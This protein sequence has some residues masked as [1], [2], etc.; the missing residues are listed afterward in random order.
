MKHDN[1][2]RSLEG[3][4][5]IVTGAGSRSD[6]I[7]NGRASAI[8]LARHGAR[9]ALI[10]ST[11]AWAEKTLDMIRQEAGD[12]YV[13]ECDV[14]VDSDCSQAV[15]ETIARWGK[16]DILVNNVG[17]GGP[18]GSAV[19][20]DLEEWDKAL[21]VN[22]TS[23]MLMARHC[24]PDMRSRK[25]GS[26]I[27]VASVAGLIGGH[28]SLLYPT[29]K[30]A[31]VNMTRAMAAHHGAEGIRVN[32]VA[33]GMVYTPMVYANGMSQERRIHRRNR[34]LLQTEGTAWDVGNAIR[35]LASDEAGWVTGAILPVDAG[36]TA[37]RHSY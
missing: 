31:V 15:K 24:I 26:I 5:A 19:D 18:T 37:G 9:V 29:S 28:P 32:C 10:D 22:V 11:P 17:I 35:Y 7:G 2:A 30:G 4:I 25:K 6:G 34:S 27:N 13:L 14:S 16:V 33:P 21:R 12:G 23:M 36:A 1:L 3:R 8:L 20:V